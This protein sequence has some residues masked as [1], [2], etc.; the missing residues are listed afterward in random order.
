MAEGLNTKELQRQLA[1]ELLHVHRESYGK[2]AASAHVYIHDDLVICL[3]DD[4]ELLPNEEFLVGNGHGEGVVDI[5][6]RY[7]QAIEAT[8]SAAVERVIGRQVISFASIT[9][10]DPNYSV[11]IFRLGEEHEFPVKDPDDG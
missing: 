4:L 6:S 7:Q 11:E 10:L 5:R 2:G 3:M 1:D 8:F 9:K